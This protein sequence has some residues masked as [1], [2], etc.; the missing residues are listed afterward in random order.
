M[1]I[2]IEEL[3]HIDFSDLS[4][5]ERIPPIHPGVHLGEL[6]DELGITPHRLAQ[7]TGMAAL[8]VDDILCGKKPVGAETALR[9]GLFFNQSPEYWLALQVHFDMDV[10]KSTL[11]ERLRR[12]VAPLCVEGPCFERIP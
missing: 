1:T 2:R 3:P 10:I 5:G 6:L 7:C 9:L 12:E 4:T 8:Q 11:F